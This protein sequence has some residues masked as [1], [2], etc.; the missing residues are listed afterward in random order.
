[1]QPL[2]PGEGI[3]LA[4]QSRFPGHGFGILA[5]SQLRSGNWYVVFQGKSAL[6]P[7]KVGRC[8][9]AGDDSA[10]LARSVQLG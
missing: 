7:G 8:R 1:M 6:G 4:A 10:S 2:R 3:S 5:L 9:F